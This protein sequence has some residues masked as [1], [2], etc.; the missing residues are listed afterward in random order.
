MP[1]VRKPSPRLRLPAGADAAGAGMNRF[2]VIGRIKH[3]SVIVLRLDSA[4]RAG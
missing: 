4:T 3:S 1:V 2:R